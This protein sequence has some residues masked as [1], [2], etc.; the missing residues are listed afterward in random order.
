MSQAIVAKT[1]ISQTTLVQRLEGLAFLVA[2]VAAY[3]AIGASWW[4]FALLLLVPDLSMAGY[5]A[6]NRIGQIT[7]NIVHAYVL[8]LALAL[9][10]FGLG[11]SLLLAIGLIWLAHIGMDRAV[12]YGLK[13]AEGFKFTHLGN[14]S[15]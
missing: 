14:L 5:W 10:G 8:P 1:A 11:Q 7:Y 3:A 9:V 6:G 4:L 15:A 12:G 13:E 2:A